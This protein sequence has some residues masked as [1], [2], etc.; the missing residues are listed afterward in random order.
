MSLARWDGQR[1]MSHGP[2]S[3]R[4]GGGGRLELRDAERL[5]VLAV[6]VWGDGHERATRSPAYSAARG[7]GSVEVYWRNATIIAAA[8][9]LLRVLTLVVHE[10]LD[11]HTV[12]DVHPEG[13]EPG[14]ECAPCLAVRLLAGLS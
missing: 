5:L 4:A 11:C 12:E 3:W 8:P 2:W 6:E 10:T 13:A 14:C 9:E 1:M 7:D